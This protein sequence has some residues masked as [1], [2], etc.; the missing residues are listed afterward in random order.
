MEAMNYLQPVFRWAHI[1]AGIT[2]IGLLYYFNFM[3][4]HIVGT[5]DGDTKKKVVPELMPRVLFWFRWGAAWTWITGVA[6]LLIVFYHGQLMF[7]PDGGWAMQSG[8]MLAVVFLGVYVY[9]ILFK[10]VKNHQAAV[11]IGFVLIAAVIWLFVDWAGFT[12]RAYVI[13][14][15]A[16]FGT[17]MA[18]N[19][20]VRIWPAQQKIITAVKN[21]EKPDPA[22][23]GLAGM[24]SKHNTYLS[25]P[26]VWTM[27]NQHSILF[28]STHWY[29]VG[30]V[31]L[32]WLVVFWMYKKGAQVK[33]F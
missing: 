7:A 30:A 3:N 19:V 8:V 23:A 17:I 6:L 18:F 9:D 25:V 29:L 31:A 16:M 33:G 10:A 26:L 13:H 12:Y 11:A 20:W 2:W 27:I 28:A 15:G 32:G 4:G 22:W 1:V 14:T 21:G 5:M 24:R